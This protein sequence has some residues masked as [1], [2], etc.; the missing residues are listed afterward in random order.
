MTGLKDRIRIAIGG[1]AARAAPRLVREIDA[2]VQTGRNIR[3]KRWILLARTRD[4]LERGDETEVSRALMTQWRSESANRFYDKYPARFG[5]WFLG[6]HQ[7]IVDE[8]ARLAEETPFDLLVEIGCGDGQVLAHCAERMPG[9]P[10]CVGIDIN[11]S[12]IARN[13]ATY[14]DRPR[15]RFVAGNAE[16]WLMRNTG[17]RTLLFSYGGVMEYFSRGSLR[18]IFGDLAAKPGSAVALVEP[19]A[20]G[21]DLEHDAGSFS[22]GEERSFSHNHGAILAAAGFEERYRFETRLGGARWMMMLA[23]VQG[24]GRGGMA[25]LPT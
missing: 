25:D 21:H 16:T 23:R 11:R 4:A 14:A 7:A 9:I 2:G 12:I 13:R 5:E 1:L 8:M 17:P 6:P 10:S 20:P 19:V 22:F 18:R 15:L 3:L 24:R